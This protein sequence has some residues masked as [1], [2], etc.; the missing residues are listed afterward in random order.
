MINFGAYLEKSQPIVYKTFSN[1][2]KN[3]RLSHAYLLSGR[4]GYP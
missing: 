4:L 2:L 1:A 3:N